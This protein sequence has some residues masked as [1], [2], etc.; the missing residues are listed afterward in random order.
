MPQRERVLSGQGRFLCFDSEAK[1]LLPELRSGTLADMHVLVV[2]DM[3]TKEVF[4]FFDR[5][6][7]RAEPKVWLDCEDEQDGTLSE[8]LRFL[9]EA[10]ALVQQN[11]TG[12]DF[13]AFEQCAPSIWLGFNYLQ[14]R[15]KDRESIDKFPN[16]VMDTYVMSCTLNP[17]RKP[18]PQAYAIGRGDVGPHS[19]EA[20][21]IRIGRY[22]P[23]N[24]DWSQLTDHM[25]HRCK[26]DVEIGENFYWFLM[27][28]W[29]EQAS[30]P[31]ARTGLGIGTAY[32]CELQMA[33]AMARQARRGF[34]FDTVAAVKL[35]EE[36]D[37]KIGATEAA[38]RP[39]MPQRIIMKKLKEPVNGCTHGSKYTAVTGITVKSGAYAAAVT[40]HYPELRGYPSDAGYSYT[41]SPDFSRSEEWPIVRGAFTPIEWEDIPLGNRETVKEILFSYGW[42]GITYN[43]KEQALIDDGK[44]DE[45]PPWAGKIDE[46]SM[47][48]WMERDPNVPEWCKK[49][50]EWYI[51]CS[52]RSQVL[53]AKDP[54]YFAANGYWPNLAGG[55]G[56]GCR[57]I[58][59]QCF[60]KE[61]GERADAYYARTGE[62]PAEG[63]WRA[64][65]VAFFAATNT[66][67]MRHKCVV[68]IP[69]SGLYPLRYLFIASEGKLVLGCD[70]AGLELRM[71]AH[72][73]ADAIYQEVV[74]SG[75]IHTYNQE[76]AGLPKRDM[77]KTFIYAFLYGSGVRNLA[78]VCDL[79]MKQMQAIIENFKARLP[80]LSGLI[81]RI[82]AQGEAFG[83][84]M[85]P[86]GRWGRI[87][88]KHGKLLVH[89]M[90]NVL[91]QMTG[92]ISM[93]YGFCFAERKM[94][95][96]KVALDETGWPAW[97]ANQHDEFQCEIP[98]H[99]VEYHTYSVPNWKEE[100]KREHRDTQGRMW[101]A[102]VL[103]EKLEDSVTCTRS[104]HRA[105][106]IMA[107]S[108]TKA[109]EFLNLRCPLAGEYKV[110]LNWQ[111][112]H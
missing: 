56:R 43:E 65:A 84:L 6:G 99:E 83:H 102:P 66:F 74:L 38:F 60:N 37:E 2:K 28:E 22:K 55:K 23:E 46:K 71:L 112:T 80:A 48:L 42:E 49:I 63:D 27:K 101:S 10:E 53:N 88:R 105:G 69:K 95:T 100:E 52:R 26:M 20:H 106:E 104:Y 75:D 1:G 30:K 57:G 107:E 97:V 68:N 93:K 81:D 50:A 58:L 12:Y 110:G 92:S 51:L 19:I 9:K 15:G 59:A 111:E 96:E 73:M 8:G 67:R 31:N 39:H 25:I 32:R 4:T 76:L 98:A 5:Y 3:L 79:S 54:E 16:R 82:Q 108:I 90:L 11:G 70:G 40:K 77:A 36:L 34:R 91:L 86:D 89:T 21:G 41:E 94:L 62:W 103:V 7:D 35:T 45:L 72:Y 44:E 64:P 87:R 109:G 78:K 14:A 18:P 61:T 85:A 47:E 29:N 13:L 33:M 17:E 24:E